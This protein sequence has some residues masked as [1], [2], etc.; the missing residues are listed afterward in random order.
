MYHSSVG[1]VNQTFDYTSAAAAG[2]YDHVT[3][4]VTSSSDESQ[5]DSSKD[6][7]IGMFSR[8]ILSYDRFKRPI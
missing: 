6:D 8:I 1:F 5:K 7:S 3:M 4:E 2:P